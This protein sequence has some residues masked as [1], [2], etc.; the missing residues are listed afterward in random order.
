MRQK[1]QTLFAS[2]ELDF[3]N[4]LY[5]KSKKTHPNEFKKINIVSE[6]SGNSERSLFRAIPACKQSL[7][8]ISYHLYIYFRAR[9]QRFP[10]CGNWFVHVNCRKRITSPFG[11]LDKPEIILQRQLLSCAYSNY[12]SLLSN[13][14]FL[15]SKFICP[16]SRPIIYSYGIT[17]ILFYII[18]CIRY[19]LAVGHTFNWRSYCCTRPIYPI[20][21]VYV[22]IKKG[23]SFWSGRCA[24]DREYSQV[25]GERGRGYIGLVHQHG[26]RSRICRWVIWRYFRSGRYGAG[27]G[28]NGAHGASRICVRD[29]TEPGAAATAATA[30]ARICNPQ[31]YHATVLFRRFTRHL[32]FTELDSALHVLH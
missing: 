29:V 26:R 15:V 14:K 13:K 17:F 12:I 24:D 32:C 28:H 21:F 31:E 7:F 5:F 23:N 10:R 4:Y 20:T 16:L 6:Y 11:R 9:R 19:I 27:Y 18:F 1:F 3:K 2:L 30:G 8:S 25:N 22:H